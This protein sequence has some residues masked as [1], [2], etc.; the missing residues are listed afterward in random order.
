MRHHSGGARVGGASTS[1]RY[2]PRERP[3]GFSRA[4]FV[5]SHTPRRGLVPV[6][7]PSPERV[8]CRPT[9]RVLS[10]SV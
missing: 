7:L 10:E 6:G 3:D 5:L 2:V 9:G 4:P 8:Q 1:T